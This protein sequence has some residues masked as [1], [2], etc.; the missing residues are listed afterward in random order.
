MKCNQARQMLSACLDRDLTF[1][2]DEELR[3]HL[4]ACPM[5]SEEL[6]CLERLQTAMHDLPETQ[7]APDFYE[8]VCRRIAQERATSTPLRGRFR[9]HPGDFLKEVLASQWSRPAVGVAFGLAIGLLIRTGPEPVSVA[10]E[11]AAPSTAPVVAEQPAAED[12]LVGS[13]E[14]MGHG[15]DLIPGPLADIDLARTD[16]ILGE[17]EYVRD[18][19][20]TDMQG[21][22]VRQVSGKRDAFITF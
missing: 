17:D 3:T 10:A 22:L 6:E 13:T 18:P 11:Q 8:A 20:V 4:R 7:P 2:E 5:C 21:R 9:L 15:E 12:L 19:Y 16:S 14:S 1:S